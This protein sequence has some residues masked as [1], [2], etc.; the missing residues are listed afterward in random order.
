MAIA[1]H[2]VCVLR[3]ALAICAI[4]KLTITD[5]V[6][7]FSNPPDWY[8]EAAGQVVRGRFA[9]MKFGSSGAVSAVES[10][11]MPQMLWGSRI[12]NA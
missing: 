6:S 2:Y 5:L 11:A 8:E 3:G 9:G 12:F 7:H 4:T 1:P 10:D